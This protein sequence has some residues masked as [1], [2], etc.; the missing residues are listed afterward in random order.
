MLHHG[1]VYLAD[2]IAEYLNLPGRQL[3]ALVR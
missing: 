3:I 2:S 1:G